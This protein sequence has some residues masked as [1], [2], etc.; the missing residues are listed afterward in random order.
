MF[1]KEPFAFSY[2][3]GVSSEYTQELA[4][5]YYHFAVKMDYEDKSYNTSDDPTLIYRFFPKKR[6]PMSE[7]TGWLTNIFGE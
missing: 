6:T 4:R 2:P 5:E 3:M 7:Y 1:G